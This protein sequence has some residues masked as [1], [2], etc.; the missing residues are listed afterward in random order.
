MERRRGKAE[1]EE[2][3]EELSEQCCS[4]MMSGLLRQVVV[5]LLSCFYE[6]PAW[7]RFGRT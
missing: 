2:G 5:S 1:G 6:K 7:V 3:E 4:S